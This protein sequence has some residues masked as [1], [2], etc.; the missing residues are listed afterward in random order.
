LNVRP[1][2]PHDAGE[3]RGV[4]AEHVA[5]PRARHRD[6]LVELAAEPALAFVLGPGQRLIAAGS[7]NSPL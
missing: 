4:D 3:R 7:V 6:L 2:L 5:A 1:V